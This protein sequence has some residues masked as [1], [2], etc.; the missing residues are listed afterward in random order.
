MKSRKQKYLD[1]V[2][3][4]EDFLKRVDWRVKENSNIPFSFSN[5][6][7]RSAGEVI[8]RY[9]LAKVYPPEVSKAHVDGDLHIHNLYMGI[10]GYC[11]G[12][13]L[14]QLL[15]KGLSGVPGRLACAPPQH[16]NTALHHVVNFVGIIQNEWAG[17]QAFNCYSE[18]TEVL[19]DNGWKYFKDLDG[20][21]NVMTLNVETEEME[22]QK[23]V[24]YYRSKYSGK[25]FHFCSKLMDLKVTPNHNMLIRKRMKN[26]SLEACPLVLVQVRELSFDGLGRCRHSIPRVGRWKGKDDK[27]FV[28]PDKDGREIKIK[29]EDWIAFLGI[30]LSEGSLSKAMAK[31]KRYRV[32]ISQEHREKRKEIEELLNRLPFN[33]VKDKENYH[34]HSKALYKYLESI[35]SCYE[36][37]IPKELLELDSG[38]LNILLT[39]LIKGDGYSGRYKAFFTT[40]KQLRD[41]VMEIAYK[42]GK[43]CSSYVW[44]KKGEARWLKKE[45][46]WIMH[47]ENVWAVVI[48][49]AKHLCIWKPKEEYY[50]GEVYCVEVPNHTLLVRRNGRVTWCGNSVDTLLAPF[51]R[52]DNLS[53][54][55]VKQA[56]QEFVFGL[57]VTSRWGGQTPFSNI[58]LD[59][60]VPDDLKNDYI[61]M[62]GKILTDT[63]SDYQEEM[64]V[65]NRAFLEVMIEG[66]ADKRPFTF[67]IPTYNITKDF[68]WG[69]ENTHMLFE[70]TA[71]YGIPYFQNFIGS[72]LDP[73][74]VR[75][76]CCRLLLNLKQFYRRL[77][78]YFGY[79]DETGSVGVVT[80]NMPRIGFLSKDE[81]DFLERLGHLLELAKD[82]LEIKRKLIEKNIER[83]LLPYTKRY[84]A[85]L[86][87]H[88]STIGLI[89]MNESCLNFLGQSIATREGKEFAIKVLKFM[90]D[91]LLEFQEE[92]G[93]I[94]N[95]EATPAEGASYRLARADKEKYP[96]IITA[97]ERVPYYT[98]S[99][100]LPVGFTDDIFEALKHQEDLQVLYT[101]GT[102]FHGFVGERI[103]D[104]DACMLLVRKIAENFKI[105]YFTITPTFSICPNHGYLVGE[106][107]KCP[108]CGEDT[109]VYSRVVGYLRPVQNWN[110]G[111]REEFR[112]RLEYSEKKLG[113]W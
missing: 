17:A 88:F 104:A 76:M 12:W 90:R 107:F 102:V 70:M 99:T 7:F 55:E 1:V 97:G 67:P 52:K 34:L 105:P 4:T 54:K 21:E 8:G 112:Q 98:N 45:K 58:T 18:D 73:H 49:S 103:R 25:I 74:E 87:W 61:V 30:F 91:R 111:K 77:G 37:R 44:C 20:S 57:N 2:K 22:Y 63:Y 15:A 36:K 35:S 64:D 96:K 95:L 106:R 51:V 71:K 83:G 72:D 43:S 38:L 50:E 82:S 110:E 69:S 9:T 40:S 89:G 13:S 79:A 66:D 26:T 46:R 94:Y 60:K 31:Q 62:G 16:L 6:F 93:N 81:N 68:D 5:I 42:T 86:R 41:D 11:A 19:T 39:W 53:Y 23:P 27:W 84:L 47:K 65:I 109:E 10:V 113:K 14:K 32:T 92:T 3:T 100:H 85:T 56:L 33:Y 59:L 78:G 75:A 28:L 108:E 24:K 29:M 80:I 48:H 101:G